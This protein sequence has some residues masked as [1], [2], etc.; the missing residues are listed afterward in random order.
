VEVVEFTEEQIMLREMVRRFARREV[1]PLAKE[2]DRQQRFP[3][4]SWRRAAE[5]GLLGVRAPERFGGEGLGLTELCIIGEEL[6]AV[7]VSTAAT[8]LHQA[9]LVIGRFA[10]HG[11]DAQNARYLPG[12]CDGTIIGCLAITEPGAGSDA[13]SM[14]TCA[15]RVDGGYRLN[16][17]KTFITNGPV[18][19]VALVYAKM[20][21]ADSKDIGLFI[22]EDGMDGFVK[23]KKFEKMGWRGSPTGELIFDDC[24]VP[25]DALLGGE[26]TGRSILMSGLDSERVVMAAE[27]VGIAQGALEISVDYARERQ[28][29][30]RPIADF[31]LIQEKLANMYMEV[32]AC[33]VLTYRTA[34]LIEADGQADTTA[35]AA[36]CKLLATE[37]CMRASS[38]AVQILG[39]YGYINE[40]PVERFMRDAKLMVIGGGTSEIQRYIIARSL[41]RNRA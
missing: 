25:A 17:T 7:C 34:A 33:R 11:S 8:I 22:V 18:A 31:Q 30:G 39:G 38:E 40:F 27:G 28:Q 3:A 36:A 19:N 21:A 12:L 23:G 15:K 20:E 13:M 24:F 9:D 10:R 6:A 32:Q 5:L 16:G 2:I 41:L 35:L 29:F 14:R 4:E 1:A 37:A 26:G